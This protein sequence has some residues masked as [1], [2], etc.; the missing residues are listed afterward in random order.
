[1]RIPFEIP[2]KGMKDQNETGS[3]IFGFVIFMKQTEDNAL[4]CLKKKAEKRSVFQ[5][6]VSEFRIN[7]KNTVPVLCI[8]YLKRHR[9]SAVNGVLCST[10]RTETAVT[11]E[12]NEFES[13]TFRTTIHCTT[14]RRITAINHAVNIFD[15]RFAWM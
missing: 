8:D 14:K 10:G 2:P 3:E 7:G 12:W 4:D 5:K 13:T 1:M 9:G 15:D 11:P 6:K